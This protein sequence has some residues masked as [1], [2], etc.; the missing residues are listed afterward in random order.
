M[1]IKANQQIE[2]A[3]N[4]QGESG[5]LLSMRIREWSKMINFSSANIYENSTL[6]KALKNTKID[7]LSRCSKTRQ[8]DNIF[9]NDKV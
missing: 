4:Q 1:G 7:H 9:K 3:E 2:G 6:C 5:N 8:T